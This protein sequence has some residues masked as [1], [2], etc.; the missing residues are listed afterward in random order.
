[1]PEFR[2]GNLVRDRLLLES[3]KR[4]AEFYLER[5]KS[6]MTAKLV[7]RITRDTRFGLAAIG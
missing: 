2:I 6:A 4:E 3:A 1:L 5:E 7:A